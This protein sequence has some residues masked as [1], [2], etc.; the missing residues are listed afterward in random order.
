METSTTCGPFVHHKYMY[1]AV[2]QELDESS[3]GWVH[4]IAAL[5]GS[6][7]FIVPLLIILTF[8]SQSFFLYYIFYLN[9]KK[10]IIYF[11]NKFRFFYCFCFY[12]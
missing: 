1:Y 12:L 8:V 7:T 3:A 9:K 2:K 11:Y 6:A 5:S 4:D 10:Y